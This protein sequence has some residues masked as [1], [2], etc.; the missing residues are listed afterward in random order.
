MKSP[1]TNFQ[2]LVCVRDLLLDPLSALTFPTR[3][4]SISE[5]GMGAFHACGGIFE[6]EI[7][8]RATEVSRAGR[9]VSKRSSNK[10]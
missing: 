9:S 2:S 7:A 5:V 4:S 6:V 1:T 3:Y 8:Q 10:S